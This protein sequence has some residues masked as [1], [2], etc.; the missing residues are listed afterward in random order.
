VVMGGWG[1]RTDV[2]ARTVLVTNGA[3]IESVSAAKNAAT[4]LKKHGRLVVLEVDARNDPNS[5]SYSPD[6]FLSAFRFM[7]EGMIENKRKYFKSFKFI[8][9]GMIGMIE[10]KRN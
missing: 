5:D 2:E 4:D 9:E 7:Q 6:Q 3:K 1:R 8:Q 10:N